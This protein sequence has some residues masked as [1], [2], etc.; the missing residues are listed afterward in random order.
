MI[1]IILVRHGRDKNDKLTRLG[2]KQAKL[3]VADLVYENIEKIFCSPKGRTRQTAKIIAK[4]LKINDIKIDE[5]LT[6]REKIKENDEKAETFNQNYLNPNFSWHNPEGCKQYYDRITSFLKDTIK[7]CKRDETILIV[8]HSSM[9]YAM[10]AF[11]CKKSKNQFLDWIRIG[12]CSK[13]C[14]EYDKGKEE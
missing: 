2:K 14:F 13:I 10:N 3:A 4:G 6:E 11:F 1:K 5:R 7:N 9:S 12:N 8:G